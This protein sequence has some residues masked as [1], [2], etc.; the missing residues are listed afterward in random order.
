[1]NK[2][3]FANVCNGTMLMDVDTLTRYRLRERVCRTL[4]LVRVTPMA[5][6]S[7]VEIVKPSQY[8]QYDIVKDA[9]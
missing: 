3:E 7:D 8:R 6:G 9:R 1:M 4:I 2:V 5:S